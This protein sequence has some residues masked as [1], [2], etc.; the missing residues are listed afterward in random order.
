MELKIFTKEFLDNIKTKKKRSGLSAFIDYIENDTE[1]FLQSNSKNI[2][3][4]IKVSVSSIS[5][6][7]HLLGFQNL[8]D[9]KVYVSSKFQYIKDRKIDD[10]L[11]KESSLQVVFENIKKHYLF[12]VEKT[13]ENFVDLK[14]LH[15]YIKSLLKYKT[16]IFFGVGESGMVAKYLTYNLRKIGQ[17][18][19]TAD[20]IHH[21]YSFAALLETKQLHVTLISRSLKTLEIK[22]IISF[23]EQKEIPYSVWTRNDNV[24]LKN[25]QNVLSLDSIN[26]KYRISS[27]GSKISS[28]LISDVIFSYVSQQ[29]DKNKTIFSGINKSIHN[30]NSLLDDLKEKQ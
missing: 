5:R 9:L 21:F 28:F 7:S 13:I 14:K 6:N 3:Y 22:N 15:Q 1:N 11:E 8:N 29:V 10:N 23:L 17:N 27:I 4:K 25:V 26:Q 12:T 30:W 16:Q 24:A 2:A 18:A 19:I 20:D